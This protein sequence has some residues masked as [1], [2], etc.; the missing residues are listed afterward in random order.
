MSFQA[1]GIREIETYLNRPNT[2]LIDLRSREEY[3]LCHFEGA[4][5]IPYDELFEHKQYLSKNMAYILYCERG[6]S[7]LMAAKELSQEGFQVYTVVGGIRAWQ[8][9]KGY[10]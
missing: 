10:D 7:S 4:R 9:T 5:N 8:E 3:E 6:G 1:I 2:R